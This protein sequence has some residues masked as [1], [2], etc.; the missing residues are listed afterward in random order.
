MADNHSHFKPRYL[1]MLAL[2]LLSE[3]DMYGYEITKSIFS[4]S[5]GIIQ[6]T[7]SALYP[8]LYRLSERGLISEESKLVGKRQRR[9]Y[10]HI[11]DAG[12]ECLAAMRADFYA[13]TDALKRIIPRP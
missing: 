10:Y 3:K 13:Y 8:V 11:K 6:V 5:D 4:R 7:E 2:Q 9:I 1:D 12:R